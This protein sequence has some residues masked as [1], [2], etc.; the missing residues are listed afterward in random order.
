VAAIG[1]AVAWQAFDSTADLMAGHYLWA[2]SIIALTVG[3]SLRRLP[4]DRMDASEESL[5]GN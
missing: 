4:L 2:G 3:Y 1:S 5:G